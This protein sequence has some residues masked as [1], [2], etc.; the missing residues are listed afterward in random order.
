MTSKELSKRAKNLTKTVSQR[1]MH[2]IELKRFH[3]RKS[4]KRRTAPLKF[5]DEDGNF[6]K[7]RRIFE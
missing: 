1:A 3:E 7:K 2:F 5:M 4:W 6:T